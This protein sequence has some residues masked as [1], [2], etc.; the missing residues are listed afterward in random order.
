M[1]I[2]N[3]TFQK[4]AN[5]SLVAQTIWKM[6]EVSR[7]DISRA[8][9]LYRSTVTNIISFLLESGVVL[10]GSAKASAAHGGR[11][12]IELVLNE[13]FGC[14]FGFDIQ[15]SHYRSMII[16][17]SGEVLWED[18]GN[19]GNIPFEAMLWAVLEKAFQALDEIKIP[20]LSICFSFPGIIDHKEGKI[21]NSDPFHVTNFNVRKLIQSRYD[22]PVYIENDANCAA[23]L[24]LT[25]SLQSGNDFENGLAIIADYHEEEQLF[26]DRLG[27]GIGVG[28]IV[29]G[30]VYHGSHEK[31]GEFR[32][33]TWTK[34]KVQ[35]NG[36]S[37]E[38]LRDAI[39]ND[40]AF[41]EWFVDTMVSFIPLIVVMDFDVV[42]LHGVP[43]A[44][45]EKIVN[46]FKS[47]VPSFMDVLEETNCELHFGTESE[48]DAA[49][50]AAMM[51]LHQLFAV[52]E[53]TEDEYALDWETV[54]ELAKSQRNNW[55]K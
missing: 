43:F 44:N 8:L 34:D 28:V 1:P 18:K 50:G 21:I 32:S 4:N 10:E 6:G 46:L 41:K 24:D 26:N 38:L 40:C 30:K 47:E 25:K 2:N 33:I 31:A 7:V 29:D 5:T 37:L 55:I 53:L 19:L 23:W 22:F 27:V 12:A 42:M 3:N 9:R 36:L 39:T 35:Q 48:M 20:L 45:K 16:S 17:I 54:I 14:V 15:P 52:P 13:K 49:K 11:K 51:Y